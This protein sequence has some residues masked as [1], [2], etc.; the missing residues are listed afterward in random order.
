[1]GKVL[2]RIVNNQLVKYLESQ[3]LI[4]PI[5]YSFCPLGGTTEALVQLQNHIMKNVF[6]GKKTH[7]LHI[8]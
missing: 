1:M 4:S 7:H 5:Q 2:E 3:N 6:F 8:F